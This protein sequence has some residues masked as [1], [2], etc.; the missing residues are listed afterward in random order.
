MIK[1]S[2]KR[3]GK[4][5]GLIWPVAEYIGFFPDLVGEVEEGFRSFISKL[6]DLVGE[7]GEFYK[8]RFGWRGVRVF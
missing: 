8:N 2:G 4:L 5:A 6:I 3:A 1:L 7:V